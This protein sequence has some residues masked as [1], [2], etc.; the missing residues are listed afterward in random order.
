MRAPGHAFLLRVVTPRRRPPAGPNLALTLTLT[1]ILTLTL[2]LTLTLNPHPNPH[3]NAH[4]Q[5]Q[6]P[7]VLPC[8]QSD[9]CWWQHR[10]AWVEGRGQST[11]NGMEVAYGFCNTWPKGFRKDA[12]SEPTQYLAPPL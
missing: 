12:T 8:L 5:A 10:D 11:H 3:P 7:P 1:L 9:G 2:T 6:A 4:L